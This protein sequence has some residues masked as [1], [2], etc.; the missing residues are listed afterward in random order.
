MHIPLQTLKTHPE[1]SSAAFFRDLRELYTKTCTFCVIATMAEEDLFSAFLTPTSAKEVENA[2]GFSPGMMEYMCDICVHA[3][4]LMKSGETYHITPAA[5]TYLTADSL[6]SQCSSLRSMDLHLQRL[7]FSLRERL[8]HG[9]DVFDRAQFFHD[10]SLPAMA[11]STLCGRIQDTLKEIISLP[12]FPHWERIIDIGGGHGLYAIAVAS[13]NPHITA[14]VQDL[15]GVTPLAEETIK[16]YGMEHQIKTLPGNYLECDLGEPESYDMVF[17]SS[18]PAGTMDVMS[19]RIAEILKPG[20]YFINVQPSEES[21]ED[22]FSQLE[23]MLWTF[24]DARESK[25]TW[26][27]GKEFPEP[28]YLAHLEKHGIILNKTITIADPYREG[29]TVKMLILKKKE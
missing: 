20:G 18:T 6:Y 17:A 19:D 4:F 25:T 28:G 1:P 5:Q 7:W 2:R 23:W 26:K 14:I 8:Y 12:E 16:E 22:I 21:T 27:K 24:S 13:E 10:S 11:A 3:G 29:Y 9:P 15:P